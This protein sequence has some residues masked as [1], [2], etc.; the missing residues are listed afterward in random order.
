MYGKTLD[1]H[2]TFRTVMD[3]GKTGKNNLAFEGEENFKK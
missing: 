3:L 2:K 1:I